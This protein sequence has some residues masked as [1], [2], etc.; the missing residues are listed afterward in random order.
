MLL[1]NVILCLDQLNIEYEA[2]VVCGSL[3][4]HV[5]LHL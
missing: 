3:Y 5:G 4:M 1:C 2:D